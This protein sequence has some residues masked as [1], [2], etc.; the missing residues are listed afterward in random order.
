LKFPDRYAANIKRAVN[1][2]TGKLN[3][4]KSLNY[5]IFIERIMPAMFCGYFK[6]DLWKMLAEL[7]CFYRQ[8]CTKQVSKAMMQRLEK[9]IIVLV[10]KMETIFH[11]GWFNVMQHLL[12]HLP[13]EASVE[14]HVQFRWMYSQERELKILRY[15]VRNKARVEGCIAVA[16]TCKEITNFSSLY[17]QCANNVNAPTTRYHVVRDVMLNDLSIFQ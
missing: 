6:A 1:V 12:V 14:R 10:C 11:P 4:L 3:G 5:H 2:G 16:L 13:W 8:I 7:N 17:F 15:T 9:E